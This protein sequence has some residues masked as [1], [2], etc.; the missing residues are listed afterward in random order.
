[1]CCSLFGARCSLSMFV[2]CRLLSNAV[3]SV[4]FV[5]WCTACCS[6]S[7]LF[8]VFLCVVVCWLLSL[9]FVVVICCVACGADC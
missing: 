3:V 7:M 9:V 5:A 1:M 2:V 8:D 4:V 6:L